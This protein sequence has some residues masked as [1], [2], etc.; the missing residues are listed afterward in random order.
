VI[1]SDETEIA[2]EDRTEIESGKEAEK[3]R[4]N[5]TRRGPEVGLNETPKK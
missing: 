3:T 2:V 4:K 5:L 1:A